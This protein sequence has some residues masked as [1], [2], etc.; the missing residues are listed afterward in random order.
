LAENSYMHLLSNSRLSAT[1][2][3]VT[4]QEGQR[5]LQHVEMLVIVSDISEVVVPCTADDDILSFLSLV[6]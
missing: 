3:H 5:Y 6:H 1:F 4:S 2:I